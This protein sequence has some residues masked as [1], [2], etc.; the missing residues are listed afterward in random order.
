MVNQIDE[1]DFVLVVNNGH[2]Y[3][4]TIEKFSSLIVSKKIEQELIASMNEL[5]SKILS[6]SSS[7]FLKNYYSKDQMSEIFLTNED[8]KS[9]SEDATYVSVKE[10]TDK[11]NSLYTEANLTTWRTKLLQN[12][13]DGLYRYLTDA[14]EFAD[15]MFNESEKLAKEAKSKPQAF[16]N[17]DLDKK[18]SDLFSD[19]KYDSLLGNLNVSKF[20]K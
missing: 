11:A 20:L 7:S 9:F 12:G 18:H 4:T 5:E 17:R 15:Q 10:S 6:L 19:S 1:T 2:L 14:Y 8:V 16:I 3:K 13:N